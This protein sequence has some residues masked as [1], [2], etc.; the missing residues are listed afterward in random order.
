[1]PRLA[2]CDSGPEFYRLALGILEQ[3]GVPFL[4][5][6]A[7]AFGAYT[8]ICRNTRDFD[9]FVMREAAGRVL[10]AFESRGYRTEVTFPHWLA[11]IYDRDRYID[12]IYSSGN[13]IAR[14]DS[15]WFEHAVDATVLDTP[16][17]LCPPEEMMW[18]KG[19]VLERERYDGCDVAHLIK[20]C[21]TSLDW[22]RLL[23]RFGRHRRVLLAHLVLFG[24][25]YPGE[26]H[27]IPRHVMS[28][29][30]D[31]LDDPIPGEEG[32]CQ[33]PLLSRSQFLPDLER[34]YRDARLIPDGTMT[35][36]EI[37]V[38]TRAARRETPTPRL[39][40]PDGHDAQRQAAGAER[41]ARSR[42]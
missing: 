21:A 38:W 2:S 37:E 24:Y 20:A 9:V 1:M 25:V 30:L 5:G 28:E 42:G 39:A 3:T 18:S 40:S 33:G 8:G 15:L 12:L 14:V 7:Y 11:K 4:V 19:F 32:L 34:G 26:R 41:T 22:D 13:G 36:D 29:L 16:V 27:L 6:G 23:W 35:R 31:R 17:R 10:R